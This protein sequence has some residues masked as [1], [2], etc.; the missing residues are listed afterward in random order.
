[1]KNIDKDLFVIM[2]N[3]WMADNADEMRDLVI[4]EPYQTAE[5]EWVADAHDQKCAYLL[6]ADND[7]NI[8]IVYNGEI[9]GSV[10][11]HK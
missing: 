3:D 4:D 5:G 7:G 6:T 10:D 11:K 1:M 2:I 8:A 9:V